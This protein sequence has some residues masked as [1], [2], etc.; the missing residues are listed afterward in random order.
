MSTA[1]NFKCPAC[2]GALEFSSGS[3]KMKCPYCD[4][5][6]DLEAFNQDKAE[7]QAHRQAAGTPEREK[8]GGSYSAHE[9]QNLGLYVCES[10]GGELVVSEHTG[11]TSCPFCGNPQVISKAFEGVMKPDLVVPFKLDKQ[12]VREQYFAHLKGKHFLPAA[13]R[14]ENHLAEFK[15]VY[16]PFWLFD[17]TM[18]AALTFK[19]EKIKR[20]EDAKFRYVEHKYYR[21]YREGTMRFENVPVDGS[22]KVDNDL[23]DSLEPFDPAAGEPYQDAFMAGYLAQTYERSEDECVG[24]AHERMESSAVKV[25]ESTV[26]GYDR[27][28]VEEQDI[29][30]LRTRARYAL[31]P[32]WLLNTTWQDKK[33]HFA[34]N[35]Q[36][37]RFVGN[38]PRDDGAYWCAFAGFFVLYFVLSF[39]AVALF[40]ANG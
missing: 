5:E 4:T 27:V 31:L 3:Q 6:V 20:W 1:V 24:R 15:G 33:F 14:D 8:G 22:D 12:K 2:G 40:M 37:G 19:C 28:S 11:A 17:S 25:I 7:Q 13:F 26:T 35:G 29:Q 16:V 32:V 21:V 36:T 9:Q 23:T 38:L 10:C 34:M 39:V 30:P 18:D